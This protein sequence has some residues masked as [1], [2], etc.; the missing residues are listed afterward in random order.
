MI[1][2]LERAFLDRVY[3]NPDYHFDNLDVLNW[4][5]VF[6]ILPIY[7]NKEMNKRVNKYYKHYKN[8]I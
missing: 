7:N 5:K 8:N 6:N 2:S 3:R 1:A 4:E